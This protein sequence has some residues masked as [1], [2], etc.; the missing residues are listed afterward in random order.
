M[1]T[2]VRKSFSAAIL[3]ILVTIL[4]GSFWQLTVDAQREERSPT[5]IGEPRHTF[6]PGIYE[7]PASDTP[8]FGAQAYA[9]DL[10][11]FIYLP[12]V[13]SQLLGPEAQAVFD[14]V[15]AERTMKGCAPLRLSVQLTAAAQGH[16]QDMAVND[17]FTHTSSDG[18]SP[19]DRIRATGYEYWSAAE[20]IAAGYSTAA[21]AVSAWMN[22]S[23]HRANILNCGLEETGVGYYY[24]SNDKGNVN[25]HHYW[26]Q[27]FATPR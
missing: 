2:R 17:F 5:A 10:D 12:I 3:V 24:L 4:V 9:V 14:L 20:N 25:Y 16:S 27:D 6:V 15:N 23:G 13:T 18:R 11:T 26:T 19:W 8:S 1:S 7:D 22:S 21:S